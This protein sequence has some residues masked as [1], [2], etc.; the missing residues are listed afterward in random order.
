MLQRVLSIVLGLLFL[1]A[2]LVSAA[3]AAGVLLAAGLLAW[4]WTWWRGRG[5]ATTQAA[6]TQARGIVIEGEYRDE[7]RR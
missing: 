5:I 2:I 4:A 7:T 3:L 1:A 6:T